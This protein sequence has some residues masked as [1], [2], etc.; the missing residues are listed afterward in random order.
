[1][2][3]RDIMTKNVECSEPTA[4]MTEL[5]KKMRDSNVGSI[6][7]CENGTLQGIVSDRDIVTRCLAENQMDAKASD[8]MS[9]DIVSGHPEMSAEE[10]G[11][12]MSEHQIRRLPI[13]ENERIAGIVALGDLSV[14]KD[15][16]R[17]AGEALS[18]IS[19]S[20]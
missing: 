4:S 14:E 20:A 5:A 9:A 12:L 10:A 16:D 7:I 17:K 1:M 6:P 2:K 13:L 19:K 18:E 11:Q 8:I 3:I 15:T